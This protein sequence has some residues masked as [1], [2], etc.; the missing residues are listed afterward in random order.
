MTLRKV[1]WVLARARQEGLATVE[2]A[3]AG[4]LITAAVV[5]AFQLL[6][7]NVGGVLTRLAGS[8]K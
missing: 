1:R 8:I 7:S 6:G 4:G 2:Y 5:T 3:I